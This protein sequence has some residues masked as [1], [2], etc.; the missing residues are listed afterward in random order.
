MLSDMRELWSQLAPGKPQLGPGL[1]AGGNFSGG[2]RGVGGQA[3][4][5]EVGVR[6]GLWLER[7]SFQTRI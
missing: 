6:K 3:A 4:I 5:D 2:L 7:D 1:N